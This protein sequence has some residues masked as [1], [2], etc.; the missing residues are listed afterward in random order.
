MK[1]NKEQFADIFEGQICSQAKERLARRESIENHIR[2]RNEASTKAKEEIR[3]CL[4]AGICPDCGGNIK[5]RMTFNLMTL[6][7]DFLMGVVHRVCICNDCGSKK[8]L[9]Y[10]Y[11]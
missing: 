2:E 10:Y 8:G 7:V 4:L 9:V 6:C 11:F 5:E 3:K 1:Q